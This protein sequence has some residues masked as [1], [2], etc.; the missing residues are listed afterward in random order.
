MSRLA[1][2]S[3][4][5]VSRALSDPDLVLPETRARV[6]KAVADLGY[7]VD[8][9]AGSLSSR[10]TGFIALMLPTLTNAN[11]AA[12]AQGLT[13]AL[14]EAEYHL[15]IAYTDYDMVEEERQL[16]NL[17]ARRPEAIVLTGAQHRRTASRM[18]NSAGVPVVEIADLPSQPIE[19]AIGFS[20]YQV[21]RT[22]ARHLIDKGFSRIGAIAASPGGAVTDHRGEERMRGFED[23]LRLSRQP[24]DWVLRH[25]TAPVSFHHG[26]EAIALMLERQDRPQ[27]VFAVSDLSA[28]GA[29]ME[30]Q[31]RGIRV[32]EDISIMGFG[33]FEIG[34]EIN[35]ALTTIHVDFRA[36]GNRTG[37]MLLDMLAS[38][39]VAE[40][41]IVD[42]GLTIIDR[43][44]VGRV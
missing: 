20:N 17:L 31:R 16:R 10:R 11:F 39:T 19:H 25:G 44:S 33:D 12:V 43:A 15:L 22:A 8:R 14:R 7:V 30:C 24:T 13:E 42:V 41:R 9:T 5:T 35:P 3:R 36:L 28:V 38:D 21:G 23:E 27:A 32:P 34:R 37:A 6:A 29:V 40:P 2:V 1:G 26:A 18:L 4:M